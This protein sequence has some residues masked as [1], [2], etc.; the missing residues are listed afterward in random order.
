[1][2]AFYRD[3][4][5]VPHQ[6]TSRTVEVVLMEEI[7]TLPHLE[8]GPRLRSTFVLDCTR[9]GKKLYICQDSLIPMQLLHRHEQLAG[10]VRIAAETGK[11]NV[12]Q[13]RELG[14]TR[15]ELDALRRKLIESLGR[16]GFAALVADWA[17][18]IER[19]P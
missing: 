12:R 1:M 17:H 6:S 14:D 7:E 11:A 10:I 4:F 16:E 5:N 13:A 19:E 9:C 2:S 15:R 18:A 8:S 3:D